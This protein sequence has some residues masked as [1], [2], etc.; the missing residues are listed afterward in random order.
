MFIGING[1]L[2]LLGF[3]GTFLGVWGTQTR[4]SWSRNIGIIGGLIWLL[5]L[6]WVV[7]SYGLLKGLF[8]TAQTF[9]LGAILS[10]ILPRKY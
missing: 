9:I 5:S 2:I 4:G 10:N 3:T 1:W 6:T 7:L 8:F